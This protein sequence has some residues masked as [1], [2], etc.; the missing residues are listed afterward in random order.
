ML[1]CQ[2]RPGA[3]PVIDPLISCLI[4]AFEVSTSRTH[5]RNHAYFSRPSHD[6]T[7]RS[8][9]VHRELQGGANTG[10]GF[11]TFAG[12]AGRRGGLTRAGRTPE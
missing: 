12:P 2:G 5:D 11:Y 8:S 9:W 10:V 6:A 7:F 1:P 4:S 3:G